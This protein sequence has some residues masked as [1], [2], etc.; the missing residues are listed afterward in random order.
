MSGG[1]IPILGIREMSDTRWNDAARENIFFNPRITVMFLSATDIMQQNNSLFMGI[2]PTKENVDDY[3]S[4]LREYLEEDRPN[5][6]EVRF[7][8]IPSRC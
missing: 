7:C 5:A 8:A 2:A 6:E 3:L 4:A 1:C